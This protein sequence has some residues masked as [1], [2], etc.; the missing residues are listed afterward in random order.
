LDMMF[1]WPKTT[2]RP[3]NQGVWTAAHKNT[4]RHNVQSGQCSIGHVD[5][6]EDGGTLVPVVMKNWEPLVFLPELAMDR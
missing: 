4:S 1:T 6:G 2:W 5:M 3:S